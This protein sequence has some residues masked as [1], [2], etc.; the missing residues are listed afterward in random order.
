VGAAAAV[1]AIIA[2]IAAATLITAPR[3]LEARISLVPLLF[4]TAAAALGAA[5]LVAAGGLG[6][7]PAAVLAAAAAA[8][9][10]G[11]ADRSTFRLLWSMQPFH[12]S[13]RV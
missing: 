5:I 10:I 9:V 8:L 13:A 2:F 6:A 1:V 12:G 7:I 4:G 11:T 3:L